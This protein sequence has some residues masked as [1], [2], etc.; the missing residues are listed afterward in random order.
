MIFVF[1]V[2]F[3]KSYSFL[4]HL[5]K[6]IEEKSKSFN[7]QIRFQELINQIYLSPKLISIA[8]IFFCNIIE[9]E[10][11]RSYLRYNKYNQKTMKNH[12]ERLKDSKKKCN[13]KDLTCL[14][15]IEFNKI[16]KKNNFYFIFKQ[17]PQILKFDHQYFLDFMKND[18]IKPE[19]SID[20]KPEKLLLNKNID[21]DNILI[22]RHVHICKKIN[23]IKKSN[24]DTIENSDCPIAK[25]ENT[26]F[27]Q[28]YIAQSVK[29]FR[30]NKNGLTLK[31]PRDSERAR[32]STTN[33]Q[34]NGFSKRISSEQ[35]KKSKDFENEEFPF[36][37]DECFT[38]LSDFLSP[39]SDKKN[40]FRIIQKKPLQKEHSVI[41]LGEESSQKS[42][43]N[44]DD[45][46]YDKM[47]TDNLTPRESILI[48]KSKNVYSNLNKKVLD[49]Y[50]NDIEHSESFD[51]VNKFFAQEYI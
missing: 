18:L 40:S 34:S 27:L 48:L 49:K 15:L 6:V 45:E 25:K 14:T 30:E 11:A 4:A 28:N 50:L 24:T 22:G 23:K 10:N 31:T 37:F 44:F 36:I 16:T 2:Y 5:L 20:P 1:F 35:S 43:D 12:Y 26:F 29:D 51:F 17:N 9:E 21:K 42:E 41:F 39:S 19:K 7:D 38:E 13:L 8:R 46:A 3:L 33:P 47:D 32:A